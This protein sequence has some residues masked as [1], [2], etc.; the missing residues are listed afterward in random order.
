MEGQLPPAFFCQAFNFLGLILEFSKFVA[1]MQ[2]SY[3]ITLSVS[4]S[5]FLRCEAAFPSRV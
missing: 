2:R 4:F 3:T 5:E 1:A